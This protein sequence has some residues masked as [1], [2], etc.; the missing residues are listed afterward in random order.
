MYLYHLIS[1][2]LQSSRLCN[3]LH[4]KAYNIYG[5]DAPESLIGG[6]SDFTIVLVEVAK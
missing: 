5:I 2:D 3:S 6:I 4:C 1:I